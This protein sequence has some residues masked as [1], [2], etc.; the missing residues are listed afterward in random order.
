MCL[1]ITHPCNSCTEASSTTTATITTSGSSG[2]CCSGLTLHLT[3]SL[4]QLRGNNNNSSNNS[5]SST[6]QQTLAAL[7][8][9]THALSGDVLA[10]NGEV[11]GG[12]LNVSAGVSDAVCLL[13]ALAATTASTG[14]GGVMS[15]PCVLSGLRGPWALVLWQPHTRRLWFGRDAIGACGWRVGAEAYCNW[16]VWVEGGC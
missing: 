5:S 8:P 10:F 14:G 3:A 6:D 16:C 4:L 1:Q 2:R 15:V 11:F 12:Q 13:D 9:L 7:P